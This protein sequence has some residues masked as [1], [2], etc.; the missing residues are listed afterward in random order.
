MTS[1]LRKPTV[2][3]SKEQALYDVAPQCRHCNQAKLHFCL[4]ECCRRDCVF[5]ERCEQKLHFLHRTNDLR[6]LLDQSTFELQSGILKQNLISDLQELRNWTTRIS[7]ACQHFDTICKT[8]IDEANALPFDETQLWYDELDSAVR[9]YRNG[10][11]K[12][13]IAILDFAHAMR[14][15]K[16]TARGMVSL[17]S[18][19]PLLNSLFDFKILVNTITT[20]AQAIYDRASPK[21]TTKQNLLGAHVTKSAVQNYVRTEHNWSA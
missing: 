15:I 2:R 20:E 8:A 1:R 21:V 7:E 16:L 14:N 6:V 19:Q 9:H 5:C 10:L 12:H 17:T 18:L 11:I 4:E 3:T 13:E